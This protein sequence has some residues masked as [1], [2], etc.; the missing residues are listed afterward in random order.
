MSRGEADVLLRPSSTIHHQRCSLRSCQTTRYL[1]TGGFKCIRPRSAARTLLVSCSCTI[2]PHRCRIRSEA[3]RGQRKCDVVADALNRPLSELTVKCA[4]EE[5]VRDYF[6][7]S[8]IAYG[9]SAAPARFSGTQ[10]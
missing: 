1:P 6:Y 3:V 10:S 8:V 5:G 2:G 4:K 7:V 9:G